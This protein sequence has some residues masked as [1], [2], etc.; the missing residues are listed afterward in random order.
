MN[1]QSKYFR[2]F[3]LLSVFILIIND[4]FLKDYFRNDITGKLSDFAGLFAFPYF[5]SVIIPKSSKINYFIIGIL[6]S[7]WK[8]EFIEPILIFFNQNGLGINR[9]VDYSDL[10]ALS[11]L[12]VSYLYWNSK[13]ND[14][15]FSNQI[16]K[17]FI[18]LICCFG[19]IATT[20]PTEYNEINLKSGL[21]IV[22]KED[23]DNVISKLK[24][25]NGYGGGN[26]YNYVFYFSNLN[27][28]V[29]AEVELS[30]NE[31]GYIKIKLDSITDSET[32]GGFL[33]GVDEEDL[34]ELKSFSVKDYEKYF[35]ENEISKFYVR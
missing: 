27:S 11:I 24:L 10:F 28:L 34:K 15:V 14:L 6:F 1:N 7:I 26:R 3:F 30:K 32:E 9:T 33:S 23:K 2:L 21:E 12:P 16:L 35:L 20:L 8:S 22:L 17:P 18:I 4:Y 19:F 25:K 5:V 31:N 29:N 13:F